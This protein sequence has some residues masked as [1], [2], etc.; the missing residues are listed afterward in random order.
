M[1]GNVIPFPTKPGPNGSPRPRVVPYPAKARVIQE[2]EGHSLDAW[3]RIVRLVPLVQDL[4]DLILS[5]G[6]LVD[7]RG[8]WSA[9]E[10]LESYWGLVG[11]LIQARRA[12]DVRSLHREHGPGAPPIPRYDDKLDEEIAVAAQDLEWLIPAL[13]QIAAEIDQAERYLHE[14]ERGDAAE[15]IGGLIGLTDR[16]DVSLSFGELFRCWQSYKLDEQGKLIDDQGE[17][18]AHISEFEDDDEG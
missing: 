1:D 5:L 11:D 18:Y 7:E 4:I 16:E 6:S 2:H 13:E 17:V 10:W 14:G 8:T 12:I 3:D 9:E 15:V